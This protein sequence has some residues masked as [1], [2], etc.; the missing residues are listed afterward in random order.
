MTPPE[1]A[2]WSALRGNRTGVRFRRQHPAGSYILDFYCAPAKLAVE[3]DG[4]AHERGNRPGRDAARDAWLSAHG[5]VTLRFSARDVA[6]DL[7]AVVRQIMSV[8]HE[9]IDAGT[10]PSASAAHCHLPLTGEKAEA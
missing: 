1:L 8:T 2:L 5:V 7:D 9:R 3:V 6:S 10:A 4:E